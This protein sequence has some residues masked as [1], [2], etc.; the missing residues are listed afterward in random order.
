MKTISIFGEH[1]KSFGLQT[2]GPLII[3]TKSNVEDEKYT[4]IQDTRLRV[5]NIKK[6][7]PIKERRVSN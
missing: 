2:K 6:C 7:L 5:A 4:S 3:K 1:I